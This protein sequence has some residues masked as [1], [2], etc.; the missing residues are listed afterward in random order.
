MTK[1]QGLG[2]GKR[3]GEATGNIVRRLKE[4]E[5][6]DV[7]RYAGISS[8]VARVMSGDQDAALEALRLCEQGVADNMA[9]FDTL[10]SLKYNDV[11]GAED[12]L[13]D[14]AIEQRK[15]ANE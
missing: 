6:T 11:P 12:A 13:I 8:L 4:I 1:P 15:A 7:K 3:T 10:G 14:Y 9:S 2:E 5:R